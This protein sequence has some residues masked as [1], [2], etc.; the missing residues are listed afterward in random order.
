MKDAG[1]LGLS[2]VAVA[3]SGTASRTVYTDSAGFYL[4][5]DLPVGTYQVVPAKAGA[6]FTPASR[7]F[8]FTGNQ[9]ITDADFA[10]P[11]S[12]TI[13]GQTRDSDGTALS[14]ATVNISDGA[15][16]SS[17][18]TVGD[19][20]Y[21]FNAMAGG[22]YTI[23]ASK[24]GINFTQPNLTF[25]SLSANQKNA[26][27]VAS[28]TTQQ[29]LIQLSAPLYIVGE[30]DQV[31]NITVTR[32]GA[33]TSAASVGFA[34]SDSAGLQNCNVFN[35]V[36]SSRCDY[37]ST[38]GAINFAAGETSKT[39]SIL[40][41]DDV[42]AEGSENFAINLTN[43][44][45]ATLGPQSIATLT[46]IDNDG[47]NGV[48]PADNPSFF[49]REHYFDFLNRQ[50][51]QSGFDFWT[52][53]IT[54]C[55][56]DQACIEVK[57]INVSAAYF[58]SIEFQGTGY[59]VERLYKS[60]YGDATGT[61][62]LGGAHQLPVPVVRLNEFL[63]DTQEIGQGVVVGQGNWQQALENNKQAFTAEFV[64]RSRFTTAFPITLTPTQFVDTLNANAGNPLSQSERD[65]LV[66]DLSSSAK[67]RAQ[68]LR[69]I[70][71]HQ[72]LVKA[73]FNRAFVLMQFF[74]YL[75]RNPNDPQDTDYTGYDFWLTKMNQFNGNFENAEMVKAFIS[76]TE[77]RQRFGP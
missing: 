53:N 16:S 39:I 3:L 46:I 37:I 77:Y 38:L 20:Y 35:G 31:A 70:A 50:P 48:N 22:S 58:L 51:D 47:T 64:Q 32:T 40:I 43:P 10:T 52:G 61:S 28:T 14:G 5:P 26:D 75:R 11:D 33:T 59:L 60:S 9:T 63:S 8:S 12:F 23:S 68:V 19:G 73:E 27:F 44:A 54:S 49:V 13:S 36:A 18:Q 69:T 7:N 2:N 67:T 21:S 17:V 76:S 1:G 71:E 15:Q 74:G 6:V 57:R 45:G 24:A 25:T 4:L 30:G 62:T 29:T 56:S 55:G 65:Q 42:Y 34:T 41:V 66:S 72:N